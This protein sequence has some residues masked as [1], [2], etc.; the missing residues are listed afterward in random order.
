MTTRTLE[1]TVVAI[2]GAGQGIG[3]G[4]AEAFARAGASLV[5]SDI[6]AA[7]ADAT[8]AALRALGAPAQALRV[9][10]RS[11]D[12]N[13][14]QVEAAVRAFG[15]L[16]VMVCNAGI[17]QVKHLLD[18]DAADWDRM[19]GVNVTGVFLSLQAAAR[20][21]L[22]QAPR[23]AGRPR[24]KIVNVA[25]VAGR[26]GAGPIASVMPHYRASKAAVISLTQSAAI[27]FA[28]Q[29]TVNAVCPGVVDTAMWDAIDRD[30]S[31][32]TGAARG[33][34]WRQRVAGVPMGRAQT[35]ADVADL[36]LFLASRGSD[37]MTG[38]SINVDGGL[39]MS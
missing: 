26:M 17:M 21:M 13:A 28:P 15:R 8:A 37:Y 33:E 19:F 39:V 30:W 29:V 1:D 32:L 2:T 24:G 22:K 14:A 25:S 5:V 9:D 6:D 35:P 4:I 10:V 3:R 36:A 31:A 38:Q 11:A 34:T 20:Q 12:D 23:A 18:L 27:T 16:D 7:A